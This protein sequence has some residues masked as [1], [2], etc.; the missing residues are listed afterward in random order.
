[1]RRITLLL[2]L[3]VLT[4]LD[5][6]RAQGSDPKALLFVGNSL[7]YFNNLPGM[8]RTLL[9]SG[10]V[11]TRIGAIT[12]PNMGLEDHWRRGVVFDSLRAGGWDVVVM[13]QGPSATEGRPSLLQYSALFADSIRAYGAEPALYMVWPAAA[14]SFDFPGVIDSYRSAAERVDGTVLP[15]GEVWLAVGE[16]DP[17]LALYGP[18]GFHP[19][20]AASYMAALVMVGR[21]AGVATTELPDG[22]LEAMLLRSGMTGAQIEVLQATVE[23][24][25]EVR[26]P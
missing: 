21:L 22:P 8:V 11:A 25:R 24:Y 3:L 17:S 19:A 13:Q 23:K 5:P 2:G 6:V 1:V 7:T 10:G 4:T 20:P 9:E 18:D 15:V 14:R 12:G 16:A 26:S